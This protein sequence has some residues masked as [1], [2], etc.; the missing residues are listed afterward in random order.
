MQQILHFIY[1][2]LRSFLFIFRSMFVGV[3]VE[4]RPIQVWKYIPAWKIYKKNRKNSILAVFK[5]C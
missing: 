5:H 3:V 4:N 1:I 2:L